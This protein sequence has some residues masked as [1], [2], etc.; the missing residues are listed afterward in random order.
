MKIQIALPS[1]QQLEISD[2]DAR[3]L[4]AQLTQL[5]GPSEPLP[6]WPGL[7]FPPPTVVPSPYTPPFIV[8]CGQQQDQSAMLQGGLPAAGVGLDFANEQCASPRN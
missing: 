2:T 8:T 7:T 6:Q 3:D 5:F 4:H 1:G